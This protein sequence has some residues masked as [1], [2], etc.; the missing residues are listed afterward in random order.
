MSVVKL[1]GTVLGSATGVLAVI[2]VV[3]AAV[4]N[5]FDDA[6]PVDYQR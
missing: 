3:I 1:L 6:A 5:Y 2:I 4:L